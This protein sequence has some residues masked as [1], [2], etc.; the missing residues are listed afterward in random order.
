MTGEGGIS[1]VASTEPGSVEHVHALLER[2]WVEHGDVLP[3]DRM[4]FEIAVTE[5]AGN[6]IRHATDGAPID[7]EL[8]VS[9]RPGSLQAEFRDSGKV[10]DV[11]LDA[12]QLPPN[13]AESGR[14]LA[15]ALAAVHELAYRREGSTNHWRIV[16][17]RGET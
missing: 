12:A 10:A 14:G 16:R 2:L 4:R 13:L 6:I 7:F 17:R 1:L 15:L 3:E 5:V 8:Q 9:V 11:D